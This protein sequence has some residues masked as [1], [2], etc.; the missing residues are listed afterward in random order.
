MKCL[1]MGQSIEYGA[2]HGIHYLDPTYMKKQGWHF[3]RDNN[4][5]K[6]KH[7][8]DPHTFPDLQVHTQQQVV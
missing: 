2:I 7:H 4:E 8:L 5:N 1:N 6:F 3:L